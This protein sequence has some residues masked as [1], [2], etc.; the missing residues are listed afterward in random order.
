MFTDEE[1]ACE[2][3]A[4]T[5]V[6]GRDGEIVTEDVSGDADLVEV[7]AGTVVVD[8]LRSGDAEE[9]VDGSGSD[10]DEVTLLIGGFLSDS[11]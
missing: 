6:A 3:G 1:E 9:V 10:I 4:D 11:F 7:G 5:S 2:V 8:K